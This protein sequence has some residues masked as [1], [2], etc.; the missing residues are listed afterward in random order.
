MTVF[1]SA[2]GMPFVTLLFR[3]FLYCKTFCTD[4]FHFPFLDYS[5]FFIYKTP[6]F[7]QKRTVNQLGVQS[8]DEVAYP[9]TETHYA[10]VVLWRVCSFITDNDGCILLAFCQTIH[11]PFCWLY[12]KANK[13]N[14]TKKLKRLG[15]GFFFLLL[16]NNGYPMKFMSMK[17]LS[18][19]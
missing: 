12:N 17:R 2:L 18:S 11:S 4:F 16:P 14:T 10:F 15:F 9:I 3:C 7:K 8:C 5:Y 1:D 13:L 6:Y 19:G